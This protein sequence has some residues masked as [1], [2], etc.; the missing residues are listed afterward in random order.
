[1]TFDFFSFRFEF[2]AIG[3]IIFPRGET[4]NILRGALGHALRKV[5]CDSLCP[6]AAL[7]PNR[8]SCAYARIFEPSSNR[9]GPSGLRNRP[10][11]VV[12]RAR[13]L[14]GTSF[15]T[16]ERF[17]FE[18]NLFET[19][20]PAHDQ[21][22]HAFEQLA[23]DGFGPQRGRAELVSTEK[24]PMSVSLNPSTGR[25]NL[26]RVEFLTPTELKSGAHL[27]SQP[28]FP[29]LLARARDRISTLRGL[30]GAGPLSIDFR[31]ISERVALVKISHCELR[32]VEATRRSSRT[33]QVHGIGGFVGVVEYS[34]EL[35]EFM[36]YLEAARFTGVG[37][38]CGWGK[39]EF[40]LEILARQ[41]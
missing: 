23:A 12:L 15:E 36:P 1:M 8:D 33:G 35:S 17:W 9:R 16:H 26:L 40:R 2:S 3:S 24:R 28:D 37:R 6:G 19:R 13:H 38:Q 14:E 27:V 34:G 5:S 31:A 29:V 10:R 20:K 22:V 32:Q 21:F 39:G 4:G 7:C 30:Y 11:P 25:V 41:S 18:V